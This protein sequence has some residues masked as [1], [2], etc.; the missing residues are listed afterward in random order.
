VVKIIRIGMDTSKNVFQLH[1]VDEQEQPVLRK[2]VRRRDLVSFFAK[3]EPT[4]VGIEAC[5]ASHYWARTLKQ[6]GHEAV[7]LPPIYVKAY[8]KRG[9]NDKIDAEA[10]CE[11]MSRPSMRTVSVKSIEQ[12]AGQVLI[13]T[14]EALLRRRTQVS[15]SIRG[16]ASEFGLVASKGLGHIEPLLVRVQEDKTMPSLAKEVFAMLAGQFQHANAQIKE[17]DAKL[18]AVHRT[19]ELS[20]RLAQVPG[21]GP[22]GATAMAIKVTDPKV[23]RCGRDFAA[24]IGLTP[25]DHTTAGRNHQSRRRDAAKLADLWC[26]RCHPASQEGPGQALALVERAR[27]TQGA[28]ARRRGARQQERPHRLEADRKWRALQPQ[29][30]RFR[31]RGPRGALRCASRGLHYAPLALIDNKGTQTGNDRLNLSDLRGHAPCRRSRSLL[32]EMV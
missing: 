10:I 17:I 25:K 29:K 8:V 4:K 31:R 1:G 19:N 14:R 7:L 21:L 16:Y 9:K 28:Q 6:L 27:Q 13:G 3:L 23:F 18:M 12:Q 5:G 30:K 2:T 26:D 11:A 22:I 24:W 15:N 20:R 32:E